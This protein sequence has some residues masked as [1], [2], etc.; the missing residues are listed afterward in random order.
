MG[1]FAIFASAF[2]NAIFRSV[3]DAPYVT[4]NTPDTASTFGQIQPAHR[5]F[6]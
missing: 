2:C 3:E 5:R 4:S 1:F 6:G